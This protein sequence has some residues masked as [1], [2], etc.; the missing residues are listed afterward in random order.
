LGRV[1]LELNLE[2]ISNRHRTIASLGFSL[3]DQ[4]GAPL[5]SADTIPLVVA[6]QVEEGTNRML[7]S[8]SKPGS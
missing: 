5:I 7:P 3:P 6:T 2:L 4:Q 1:P 8:P